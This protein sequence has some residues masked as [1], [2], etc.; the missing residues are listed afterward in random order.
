MRWP[1]AFAPSNA[2]RRRRRTAINGV[3]WRA[4]VDPSSGKTYYFNDVSAPAELAQQRGADGRMQAG[5]TRW[6]L[7]T[8]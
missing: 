8:A 2:R 3:E 5:E 6:E 1:L 4:T 7:P